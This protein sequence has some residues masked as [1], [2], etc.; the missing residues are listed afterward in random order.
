MPPRATIQ[1]ILNVAGQRK[2]RSQVRSFGQSVNKIWSSTIK[3]I[4]G[5]ALGAG[6]IYGLQNAAKKTI[7]F[8]VALTRL[9]IQGHKT[10]Q[11]QARVRESIIATATKTGVAKDQILLAGKSIIDTT[12]DFDFMAKSL[13]N[14]A[15]L[16]Q[17]TGSDMG[18]L[19]KVQGALGNQFKMSAEDANE[20]MRILVEQGEQGAWTLEEMATTAQKVFGA[21][22]TAGV[23][24]KDELKEFTAY[25]QVFRT[26]FAT[27]EEAA[28][29]YKGTISRLAMQSKKLEGKGIKVFDEDTGK[30]RASAA[31]MV[32]IFDK[33]GSRADIL[34]EIF[35]TEN[36]PA[37]TAMAGAYE[38]ATKQGKD[39]NAELEKFLKVEG[40]AEKAQKDLARIL[41]TSGGKLMTFQQ[42]LDKIFD[43]EFMGNVDDLSK[44]LPGFTKV[45]KF[46]AEN[47]EAILAFWAAQ[48]GAG[49]LGGLGTAGAGLDVA[50]EFDDL[51]EKAGKGPGKRKKGIGGLG[52]YIMSFAAGYFGGQLLASKILD[53]GQERWMLERGLKARAIYGDEALTGPAREAVE[54]Y[55]SAQ[56]YKKKLAAGEMPTEAESAAA[57]KWSGYQMEADPEFIAKVLERVLDKQRDILRDAMIEGSAKGISKA[58][59]KVDMPTPL[60]GGGGTTGTPVH[61]GG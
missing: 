5:L 41:D 11:S 50:D 35:G 19:G 54:S 9:A 30:M 37:V 58:K 3:P 40:S 14:L 45:L 48:K 8:D 12:G 61:E 4:A 44:A 60:E 39:L 31:I 1:A 43:D 26:G 7:D 56:R 23:R 36:L 17:T 13:E 28:T 42:K 6:G 46:V 38:E 18:A 22:Y 59:I 24:T 16:S 2:A 32:D 34:T 20:F 49:M 25:M 15:I 57:Q 52:K 51:G 10:A 33:L 27:A 29:A 55:E 21:A 47:K 53:P